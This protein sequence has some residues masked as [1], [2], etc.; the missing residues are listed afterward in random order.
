MTSG[1]ASSFS[2][3]DEVAV[4]G[5]PPR[6]P[7][8][9]WFLVLSICGV[10]VVQLLSQRHN[11]DA[12][13]TALAVG[14]EAL[15]RHRYWTLLTYAWAHALPLRGLPWYAGFHL[16]TNVVPLFCL[17]PALERR[18]GPWWLL[19]LY[20]GGAVA[21]ALVWLA[22]HPRPNDAMIGASGALFAL[23]AAAGVMNVQLWRANFVFFEL[24][25]RLNL[26]LAALVLCALEAAQMA[27]HRLPDVAH[28]AHLGGAFF[29]A[30][31]ALATLRGNRVEM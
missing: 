20:F 12:A 8:M 5:S 2:R 24:P 7:W 18:R 29:G 1:A 27:W 25:L 23:I 11:F 6:A 15:A 14:P 16:A 10:Y 13:G 26:R 21:S 4:F 31:F 22:C 9:T 3:A 28:A 17:A 30:C 19:A